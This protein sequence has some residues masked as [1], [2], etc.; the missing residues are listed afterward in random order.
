MEEFYKNSFSHLSFAHIH[1]TDNFIEGFSLNTSSKAA[2]IR[3]NK[4]GKIDVLTFREIQKKSNI[5]ISF[6]VDKFGSN[7]EIFTY[8][9]PNIPLLSVIISTVMKLPLSSL[10]FISPS[11][12]QSQ[13]TYALNLLK[14]AVLFIGILTSDI[15][16]AVENSELNEKI[17]LITFD[18]VIHSRVLQFE[19]LSVSNLSDSGCVLDTSFHIPDMKRTKLLMPTSG[20]TGNSKYVELSLQKVVDAINMF[21][22]S[23]TCIVTSQIAWVTGFFTTASCLNFGETVVKYFLSSRFLRHVLGIP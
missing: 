18:N 12:N 1:M 19:T 17:T 16:E 15:L 5:L 2:I 4:G 14:P 10:S 3:H 23:Q 7:N 13:I 9:G 22:V 20:T 6:L 21:K 8:I 11:Q